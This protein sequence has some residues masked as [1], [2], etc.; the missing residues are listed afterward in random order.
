[1]GYIYTY[2]PIKTFSKSDVDVAVPSS[3]VSYY[4]DYGS[5]GNYALF[6]AANRSYSD[7]VLAYDTNLVQSTLEPLTT[8]TR[9]GCTAKV[10]D[11]YL[12]YNAGNSGELYAYDK[13]LTRLTSTELT[14]RTYGAGTSVAGYA[15]IGG[16]GDY[17]DTVDVYDSTLTMT[18]TITLS[19]GR[20]YLGASTTGNYA[21]F[22]MG[23]YWNSSLSS[24][25]KAD[26]SNRIDAFSEDLVN[27]YFTGSTSVY[28]TVG[29]SIEGYAFCGTGYYIPGGA[30]DTSNR[31][32]YGTLDIYNTSLTRTTGTVQACYFIGATSINNSIAVYAG[33]Y[34]YNT[35]SM[36][37]TVYYFDTNLTRST[38]TALSVA[39]MSLGSA[40]V[41]KYIL[42]VGGDTGTG[43]APVD[44]VDVY[45]F[46]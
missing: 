19:Q 43:G 37:S 9:Y 12:L 24:T 42:F 34:N 7:Q 4:K 35:D 8:A 28:Y 31:R 21:L 6:F 5:I 36:Y 26:S 15:L 22:S 45:Q 27:T 38:S 40:S 30:T 46:A 44:T 41:G 16:G 2:K 11:D 25:A 29:T 20:A 23:R 39:R 14:Q 13:T 10:G 1:M 17:L 18:T 32:S 33:G 3:A